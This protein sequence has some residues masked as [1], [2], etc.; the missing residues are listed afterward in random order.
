M[1][2]RHRWG[3]GLVWGNDVVDLTRRSVLPVVPA[4]PLS[5]PARA[6]TSMPKPKE[7]AILDAQ[8]RGDPY[9]TVSG[10]I[11]AFSDG[12]T[13]ESERTVLRPSGHASFTTWPT[14]Y[15]DPATLSGVPMA[16]PAAMVG[17]SGATVVATAPNDCETRV[18]V[19]DQGSLF[20]VHPYDGNPVLNGQE[21]RSRPAWKRG[22][23]EAV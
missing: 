11:G 6:T 8:A 19:S 22:S 10:R 16:K 13:A 12:M 14:W 1:Y 9:H 18:P 17:A 15:S 20:I 7:E 21:Y 23:I 3:A 2:R 5:G 4:S